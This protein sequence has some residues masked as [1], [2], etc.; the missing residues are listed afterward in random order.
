MNQPG[1]TEVT[2]RELPLVPG[3]GFAGAGV[4]HATHAEDKLV[5][6][7]AQTAGHTGAGVGPPIGGTHRNKAVRTVTR[8]TC[9]DRG[10]GSQGHSSVSFTSSPNLSAADTHA[11]ISEHPPASA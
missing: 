1:N 2:R 4:T 7:E 11:R 3:A 10:Q 6:L 8:Q 9:R 5:V